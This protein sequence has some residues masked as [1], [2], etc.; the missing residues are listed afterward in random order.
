MHD[1]LPDDSDIPRTQPRQCG[2]GLGAQSAGDRPQLYFHHSIHRRRHLRHC[3]QLGPGRSQRPAADNS[4]FSTPSISAIT[5]ATAPGPRC[6]PGAVPR[7]SGISGSGAGRVLLHHRS[8]LPLRAGP[9]ANRPGLSGFGRVG[10]TVVYSTV[11]GPAGRAPPACSMGVTPSLGCLLVIAGVRRH[12]KAW[13][14]SSGLSQ[15]SLSGVCHWGRSYRVW[16][17]R[18]VNSAGAAS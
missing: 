2:R 12:C 8:R 11:T 5:S 13:R 16:I 14:Q 10:P 3:S 7:A 17:A 15:W 6:G 1:I 18:G 4:S 9:G